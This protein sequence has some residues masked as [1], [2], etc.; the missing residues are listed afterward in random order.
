MNSS[1][2]GEPKLPVNEPIASVLDASAVLAALFEEPGVARVA[3]A[4]ERGAAMSSVNL[5][6]V[7]ARLSREDWSSATVASVVAE[8][9]IEVIPFDR[10]TAL[11]SGAYRPMTRHV[12][13]GLGD[14]ACLATA[15]RLGLPALTAD[16]SWAELSIEGVRVVTIR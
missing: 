6:E 2:N 9:G 13:L 7:A 10:Q 5:A 4:L 16:R 14:R 11:L 12:G 8:M 1:W 15:C 3:R